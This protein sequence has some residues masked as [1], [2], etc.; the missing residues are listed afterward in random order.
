MDTYHGVSYNYTQ[1][2]LKI[3]EKTV[4]CDFPLLQ[5]YYLALQTLAWCLL[6]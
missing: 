4:K 1:Y 3:K 6:D 5:F 2:I